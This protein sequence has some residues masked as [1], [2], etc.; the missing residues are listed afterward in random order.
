M[1]VAVNAGEKYREYSRRKYVQERSVES[2]TVGIVCRK[3][4]HHV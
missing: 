1:T 4:V 3:E 2:M